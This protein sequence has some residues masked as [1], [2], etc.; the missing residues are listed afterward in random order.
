[1]VHGTER[2]TMPQSGIKEN[3]KQKI[4]LQYT[5]IFILHLSFKKKV[6]W[7]LTLLYKCGF[8]EGKQKKIIYCCD[9]TI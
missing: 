6:T 2:K 4:Q 7:L 9:Q 1:M 8:T 3:N 5:N